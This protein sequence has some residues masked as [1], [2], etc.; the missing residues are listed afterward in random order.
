MY[1]TETERAILAVVCDAFHPRL[2]PGPGDDSALFSTSASDIGVPAAA[3][4]AIARLHPA[5]QA[6]LRQLLRLLDNALVMLLLG[7]PARGITSMSAVHRSSA[8]WRR[9]STSRI[10]QLRS[11]F[12]ALKRLSSFL[13]YCVADATHDNRSWSRLGYH[14]SPMP[15]AGA[16]LLRLTT[17]AV[18]QTIDADAC[19]IGSG[20]GRRSRCRAARVAR[21]PRRRARGRTGRSGAGFRPA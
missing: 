4:D 1:L 10:P 16:P 5:Q 13:Y 6:E 7:G 9:L 14:P 2:T 18:P 3:E 20:A 12:Q 15:R 21:T 19:V 17:V 8:C 11:G